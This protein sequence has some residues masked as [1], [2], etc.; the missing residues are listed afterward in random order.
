MSALTQDLRYALRTFSNS[1]GATAVAVV[2]L[3]LGIGANAAIFSV[4]SALLLRSLPYKDPDHLVF[5]WETKLSKGMRHERLSPADFKDFLSQ[6]QVLDQMGAIRSQS[7]VVIAGETPERIETA[8]VSPVI[9]DLLAMKPARGRS[10]APDED[11]PEKNHVAILSNGLW[12]RRFGQDPNILGK[13]FFLDGGA[14]TVVGVAR[15]DFRV[16]ASQSELWIPYTPKPSELLPENRVHRVPNM[17][18]LAH[19]RPGISLNRAQSELRMI[20]DG[21]AREYPDTNAG[22]SVDLVPL[23]GQLVGD[24]RPTLWMLMAAV[25][26]VLLIACVNVAHLLLARAGARE[27]EIAVRT[28]LGAN[29]ARL[30]RQLLTESVVLALMAGLFGLLL[31]YWGVWILEKFAPAGL[32]QA[33]QIASGELTLDWRVLIFTLGVSIFTGI[34]FGLAPALSCARSNLN[35]V[36]RSGGRGG[37]GGRARSRLRDVLMVC[38]VAC[39]AALLVGAGLLLRSL[40][41]LQEV[42]PGF[43]VDHILTMQLSLPPGRYSGLKV[44]LF[45]Q[46]LLDRVARLPGVQEAGICRFLPLSGNDA[47]LNFQIE[48]QPPLSD[49]DQPRAK[50]RT[51]SG[52]YF[53]A[54]GIPLIRGR[55]FDSRDDQHTPKV[56]IVNETAARRYWPGDDPVGKRILSGMDEEQR[57]W[58]TIIGVVGDVKHSGLDAG[59]NPETYYHYLQVPPETVNIAEGTMALAIRTSANPDATASAVRQEL[60]LLDPSQPVFSVQTMQHLLSNSIAQPRFRTFFVSVFAGLALILVALGLYGVVAYSVSQR[61]TE[62]GIRVALGAQPANILGLVL[63]RVAGLAAIGLAIGIGISLAGG[64]IISKFLFGVQ[65]TDPITLGLV[66]LVILLV[67]LTASLVPSLRAARVDPVITLRAE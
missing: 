55:L 9:F 58:S 42:N 64:R 8:A 34:A 17:L 32:P 41:H 35:L 40:L 12:R 54:L 5:I 60:R 39:S 37:T 3:S 66:C 57:S 45:Y 51:A 4:T 27:K 47:S 44:G 61:I 6:N 56:A 52:G 38:E 18:V 50:F 21:L 26:A 29:P 62:L 63:F 31:A 36:L 33:G 16:P 7:S 15:S 19:L 28:A 30:V 24:I 1:P 13:T 23:R 48:G 53:E 20:A 25:L 22:Y 2:V 11:Q 67:A 59:V 43:R 46:Q 49:A 14:F 65:P 10:F